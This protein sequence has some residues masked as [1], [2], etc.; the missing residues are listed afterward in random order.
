ME[1]IYKVGENKKNVQ[2]YLF[3]LTIACKRCNDHRFGHD[4]IIFGKR[5]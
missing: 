5:V 3:G 2:D 4:S 1:I